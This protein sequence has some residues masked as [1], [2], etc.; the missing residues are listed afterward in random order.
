MQ[1]RRD[2]E[3]RKTKRKTAI[4]DEGN[5]MHESQPVEEID[6]LLSILRIK[7]KAYVITSIARKP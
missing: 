4:V 1:K 2:I 6:E 5:K 7:N 3:S